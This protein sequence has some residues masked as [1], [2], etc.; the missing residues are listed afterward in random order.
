[1]GWF[2]WLGSNTSN[3]PA[4]EPSKDGGYIAPDR[5]SRTQCWEARDAFFSCLDKNGILDSVKEDDKAKQFCAPELKQF[6]KDCA[7]SWV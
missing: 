2:D 7:M 1:M 4:P 5:S 3:S 6:E